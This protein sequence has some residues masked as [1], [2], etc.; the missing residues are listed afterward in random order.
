MAPFDSTA[1]K[2]FPLPSEPMF[3]MAPHN[4]EEEQALL[5]AILINNEAFYRVQDFLEPK[6]FFETIHGQIFELMGRFIRLNKT[7]NTVTLRTYLPTDLNVAGLTLDQYLARLAAEG[8]DNHQCRGL[9]PHVYDLSVRRDSD[10]RSARIWSTSPT[11]RRS[12]PRR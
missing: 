8:D 2:P 1:R 9:W 5:G 3:R 7:V 11:T 6:H 10:R 4:I 12:M